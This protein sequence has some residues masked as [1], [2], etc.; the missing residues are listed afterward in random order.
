[1]DDVD[2]AAR[3]DAAS[4]QN[5]YNLHAQWGTAMTNVPQRF[6]LLA[7]YTLPVGAGGKVLTHTPV[8]SQAIGHWKISTAAQFQQD[9][10]YFITQSNT[11]GTL[12]HAG[13][14]TP[15]QPESH[16]RGLQPGHL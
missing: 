4:V 9:Y 10:P 7:V 1:L 11:L 13:Q 15:A 16:A 5:V 8:L 3:S 2:A 14:R 6:S 12:G